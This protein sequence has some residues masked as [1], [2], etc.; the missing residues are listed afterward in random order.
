[1]KKTWSDTR[2]VYVSRGGAKRKRLD[3]IDYASLT[4]CL[5]VVA[6]MRKAMGESVYVRRARGGVPVYTAGP[7]FDHDSALPEPPGRRVFLSA[8]A[9]AATSLL[10]VPIGHAGWLYLASAGV[11]GAMFLRE[12]HLL[13]GRVARGENP[14]PMRL[15]HWSITYLTFL[16]LA[17]ALGQLVG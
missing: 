11:L 1:M 13:Q 15:F 4:G 8:A 5:S 2:P 16:F 10:L 6:K 14:K 9:A 3:L 17:I 7:M 12:S